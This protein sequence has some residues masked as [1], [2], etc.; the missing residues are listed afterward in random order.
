MSGRK[1]SLIVM[2]MLSRASLSLAFNHVSSSLVGNNRH[3]NLSNLHGKNQQHNKQAAITNLPASVQSDDM[4]SQSSSQVPLSLQNRPSHVLSMDEIQPIFNFKSK[5]SGKDK[6]LNA[7]GILHLAVIVSTMPFWMAAMKITEWLG[8]TIEGFDNNRAKFDYTGKVW[9]RSYLS[10]TDSY[11]IL[12]GD[13]DRLKVGPSGEMSEG[14]CLFVANHASFLDIAVL[15]TVLDP[16]FK[17]IAKDSLK[18]F[19]GVGTQ[20]VGGE[21]VLIDRTN[22]RSQ[23]KTFKQAINY[24]K[25]GIPIMAFPEG[26]RSPDGR[27]MEF[28]GG[29]FSMA[30][31][32]KVPIV[33]LSI[34][35]THAVMPNMGFLPVQSGQKGELRVYVHDPIDVEGKSEEEISREVRE[36]LLRELPADQHP[37]DDEFGLNSAEE[38]E[39]VRA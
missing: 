1:R 34:A 37:L 3:L 4:M 18:K 5:S 2:A 9:C 32:A 6:V 11:P 27:L 20:L 22:K 33:P 25:D 12:E 19:P 10:M 31:K 26:A 21:H 30:V 15:C 23:L 13:V 28:K 16:V 38:K 36:A 24:L 35:N 17:F 14:A 29:I 8:N 39:M 7:T